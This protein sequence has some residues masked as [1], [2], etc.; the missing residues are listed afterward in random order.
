MNLIERVFC[1]LGLHKWTRFNDRAADVASREC[2]RCECLQ[3]ADMQ[4][5]KWVKVK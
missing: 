5:H 4:R 3:V 1:L 2:S